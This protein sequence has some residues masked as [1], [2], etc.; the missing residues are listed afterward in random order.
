MQFGI[1]DLFAVMEKV[2][3]TQMSLFEYEDAETRLKLCRNGAEEDG[4]GDAHAMLST[5][6]VQRS[7]ER[8]EKHA[9]S[10]QPCGQSAENPASKEKEQEK[11]DSQEKTGTVIVSPMVGTFYAAPSEGEAPFVQIGDS[12]RAGQTL[13]IVEAMKLMNEIEAACSGTVTEI[14]ANNEQMVEFGQPLFRIRE[15]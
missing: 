10:L 4:T 6:C 13:G 8:V 3:E 12:V 7:V 5:D 1:E 2:R 15:A 11:T 14:L 9:G